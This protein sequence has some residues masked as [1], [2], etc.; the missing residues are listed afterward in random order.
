MKEF[1]EGKNLVFYCL[2]IDMQELFCTCRLDSTRNTFSE[3][4]AAI[5]KFNLRFISLC[6]WI[7]LLVRNLIRSELAE[8]YWC[9]Y[10]YSVPASLY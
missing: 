10:T 6:L 8:V 1:F 5:N 7:F 2:G 9:T 3:L 4:I